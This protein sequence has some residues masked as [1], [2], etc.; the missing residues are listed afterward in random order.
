MRSF[1]HMLPTMLLVGWSSVA[2]SQA[3]LWI[4]SLPAEPSAAYTLLD[5]CTD[6]AGNSY[7]MLHWWNW[8]IPVDEVHLVAYDTYGTLLWRDTLAQGT[9]VGDMAIAPGGDIIL[10]TST[11]LTNNGDIVTYRYAPSGSLVW[12]AVFNGTGNALDT[13][14][15]VHGDAAGN[16]FV[17]GM[18][19]SQAPYGQDALVIGYSPLGVE[20]FAT[21][22]DLPALPVGEGL[23]LTNDADGFV[24]LTGSCSD[25]D[26]S[27]IFTLQVDLSGTVQWVH[28]HRAGVHG[29]GQFVHV[30][31]G[32]NIRT[33]GVA[34]TLANA[35]RMRCY[36]YDQ[37]GTMI[38][39]F[40]YG[41]PIGLSDVAIGAGGIEY[42]FGRHGASDRYLAAF[43]PDHTVLW[44]V[45]EPSTTLNYTFDLAMSAAEDLFTASAYQAT[46][47]Q[48]AGSV[49]KY[50][51]LGTPLWNNGPD[52]MLPR[53]QQA[54]VELDN[55]GNL[56]VAF[57][58]PTFEATQ[59][60]LLVMKYGLALQVPDDRVREPWITIR[61]NPT[62][63]A[64]TITAGQRI[65]QLTV[66]DLSGRVVHRQT[67]NTDEARLHLSHLSPGMYTVVVV[68]PAGTSGER[69]VVER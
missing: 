54:A 36:T 16:T 64:V 6:S 8:D 67:A 60:A 69:L 65:E 20:L 26:S 1:T 31:P 5:F 58:S 12:S 35:Y 30:M 28:H 7:A 27:S 32:G 49:R 41:A 25:A 62:T 19:M 11:D 34:D 22:Y 46:P 24:Y 51:D 55:A 40:A 59:P 56:Y 23:G 18:T 13:P 2:F 48:V 63:D 33:T 61:P 42:V 47:P 10:S 21:A 68:T 53:Y 15:R 52:S 45:I 9:Y 44:E 57:A 14:F 29:T 43:A 50:D 37:A 4:D 17:S 38:D 3:P 66:A 39:S